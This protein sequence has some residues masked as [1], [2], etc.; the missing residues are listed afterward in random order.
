MLC[1]DA[2]WSHFFPSPRRNPPCAIFPVISPLLS[3]MGWLTRCSCHYFTAPLL[4]TT[5]TSTILIPLTQTLCV[6]LYQQ[7]LEITSC[8]PPHRCVL[9]SLWLWLASACSGLSQTLL[10]VRATV[11]SWFGRGRSQSAGSWRMSEGERRWCGGLGPRE[12][13]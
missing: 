4:L 8:L 5:S 11:A 1:S 2:I 3:L 10:G 6:S 12:M 9:Q 13:L 7:L